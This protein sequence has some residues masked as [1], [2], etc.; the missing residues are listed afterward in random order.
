VAA[1]TPWPAGPPDRERVQAEVRARGAAARRGVRRRDQGPA[2]ARSV[3][4]AV[5]ASAP[6]RRLTP[7]VPPPAVSAR[8]GASALK[9]VVRRLT[10]WQLDPVVAHVNALQRAV[11]AMTDAIATEQDV[12]RG[13]PAADGD[14]PAARVP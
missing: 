11:V 12:Q 4:A 6:V 13:R 9:R 10:A 7:L 14:G 5:E 8:P 2:T 3:A 1:A